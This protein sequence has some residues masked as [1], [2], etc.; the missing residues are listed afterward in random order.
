MAATL[1]KEEDTDVSELFDSEWIDRECD[2]NS[3]D[4]DSD[5]EQEG[6]IEVSQTD[7]EQEGCAEDSE[8][9]KTAM[10]VV[11]NKPEIEEGDFI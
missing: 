5:E 4:S 6:D 11:T 9:E 1:V 8:S 2:V 10:D 3:E 7:D